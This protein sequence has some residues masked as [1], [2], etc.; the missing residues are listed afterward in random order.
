MNSAQAF[1]H[2]VLTRGRQLGL[3]VP[4]VEVALSDD[5]GLQV[6]RHDSV[7]HEPIGIELHERWLV[8]DVVRE[9]VVPVLL[10]EQVV[11]EVVGKDGCSCGSRDADHVVPIS[12]APF[13]GNEYPIASVPTPRGGTIEYCAETDA[14]LGPRLVHPRETSGRFV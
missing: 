12:R 1:C 7:G 13:L 10:V 5:C 8:S 6:R 14:S 3:L 9:V 2:S 4:P 11:E